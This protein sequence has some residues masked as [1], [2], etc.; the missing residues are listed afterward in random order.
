MERSFLSD[1]MISND[2]YTAECI[3]EESEGAKAQYWHLIHAHYV[4][5]VESLPSSWF[6]SSLYFL[7]YIFGFPQSF[8]V[9]S[10]NPCL[11]CIWAC[12]VSFTDEWD[13]CLALISL[14]LRREGLPPQTK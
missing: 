5:K 2:V 4:L 8:R 14:D 7:C 13:E 10:D 1:I 3:Y 6:L 12:G 9:V 11:Y